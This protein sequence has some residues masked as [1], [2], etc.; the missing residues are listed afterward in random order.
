MQKWNLSYE[1]LTSFEAREALRE[2]KEKDPAFWNKLTTNKVQDLPAEKVSG[3]AEDQIVTTE[4][5]DEDEDDSD[6]P[7]QTLIAMVVG[8]EMPDGVAAR[9]SSSLMS[10]RAAESMSGYPVEEASGETDTVPEEKGRG[11]HKKMA[12]R[13]YGDFWGYNDGDDSDVDVEG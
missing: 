8:D 13:N 9:S 5:E 10:I 2:M 4:E 7:I 3:L 12:N 6:V 11:K 1:C